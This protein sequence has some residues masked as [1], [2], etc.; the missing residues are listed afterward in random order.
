M[1]TPDPIL[2]RL[3]LDGSGCTVPRAELVSVVQ[4][5]LQSRRLRLARGLPFGELLLRELQDFLVRLTPTTED[6]LD[7][8]QGP[9]D[10]LVFAVPL[11]CWHAERRPRAGVV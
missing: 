2:A 6:M 8:R 3:S 5:L 11:A 4:A 10:D 7:W 9:E 1:T